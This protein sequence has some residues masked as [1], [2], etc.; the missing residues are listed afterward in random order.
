MNQSRAMI[1]ILWS[2]V[3]RCI[4][5]D[6]VIIK[7]IAKHRLY[8]L[9]VWWAT[10]HSELFFFLSHFIHLVLQMPCNFINI[11]FIFS[12]LDYVIMNVVVVFVFFFFIFYY[13]YNG[14]C[15]SLNR[16]PSHPFFIHADLLEPFFV[17][18]PN[19]MKLF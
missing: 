12:N 3:N 17:V 16:V 1:S 6:L 7:L 9:R 14:I 2:T 5:T 19:K 10:V 8:Q 11:C 4:H 18:Q 13:E 15:F